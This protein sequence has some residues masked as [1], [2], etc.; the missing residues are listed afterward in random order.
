MD[1][2]IE[3][4]SMIGG[5]AD[6]WKV[7][8]L[9]SQSIFFLLKESITQ[10]LWMEKRCGSMLIDLPAHKQLPAHT[11]YGQTAMLRVRRSQRMLC[12]L[13]KKKNDV[14]VHNTENCSCKFQVPACVLP[15]HAALRLPGWITEYFCLSGSYRGKP[16]HRSKGTNILMGASC[17]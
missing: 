14:C 1:S 17:W 7:C 15:L 3:K 10:H 11:R 6:A 5:H 9:H 16:L 12:R 4:W 13:H 2:W 8:L